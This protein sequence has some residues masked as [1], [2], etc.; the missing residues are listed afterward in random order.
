MGGLLSRS[1]NNGADYSGAF[2]DFE[3]AEP[4]T[5]TEKAAYEKA[6]ACLE[7]ASGLLKELKVYTGADEFIRNAIQTP[8]DETQQAAW[9]HCL[10]MVAKLKSF[11][12]YS[13]ELAQELVPL[14]DT[15]CAGEE[16]IATTILAN[17]SLAK[18]FCDMVSFAFEFDSMKL[19]NPS[20]QNDFSFY[21]RSLAKMNRD[22]TE[23]EEELL[24]DN[25][26][27]TLISFFL[28][29]AN[30]MITALCK[31][32]KQLTT[33]PDNVAAALRAMAGVAFAMTK[34]D[35]TNFADAEK[36]TLYLF[37]VT[38]GIIV[39][40]DNVDAQGV[41]HKKSGI[42]VKGFVQSMKDKRRGED[43]QEDYSLDSMISSIRWSTLHFN[44]DT[45][46]K[47]IKKLWE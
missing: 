9:D 20:I 4:K 39:L 7:R 25:E 23:G 22:N 31:G 1:D 14:F 37:R 45:T 38:T 34:S 18:L 40:Y 16:D 11:Y 42:D 35:K 21:K 3:N 17:E 2:I 46:P 41:F 29:A 10:P 15:M 47:D 6:L 32:M 36:T 24:V 8:S 28:A 33:S 12:D 30:P 44:E 27:A 13:N 19:N 5:D 26:L 43:G